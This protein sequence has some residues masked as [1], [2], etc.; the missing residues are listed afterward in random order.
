MIIN[1]L[2]KFVC[3]WGDRSL[4][5]FGMLGRALI[6]TSDDTNAHI[7]FQWQAVLRGGEWVY[8]D[9]QCDG[10]HVLLTCA[11]KR[12]VCRRCQDIDICE[13]CL[14]RHETGTKVLPTCSEHSFLAL[15]SKALS[16]SDQVPF[17]EET[18][19]EIWLQKLITM[20]S[21]TASDQRKPR[22]E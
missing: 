10:C 18:E 12:F 1:E 20:Y 4:R 8:A 7:A 6:W 9:V 16:R 22:G 5:V 11:M 14:E 13:G 19:R 17:A 3:K 21:N 15:P 2:I